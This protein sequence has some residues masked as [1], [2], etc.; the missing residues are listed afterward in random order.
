MVTFDRLKNKEEKVCVVGLGYV[1]LPLAVLFAKHFQVVGFDINKKRI[2]ELMSGTDHTKEV[3]D[4]DLQ[5]VEIDYTSD[6][7]RISEAKF[8]IVAVP[9]PIDEN[10]NP[11]LFLVEKATETV[12][13]HLTK[14]SVV[15]YESTVYPG[16]TEEICLPI[17]ERESGL[18][19]GDDFQIGY[20]P[21]RVN[22]G[23][24]QHTID[25]ITKVVAGYDALSTE[26][27]AQVYG[28]VTN[29]FK[30]SSIK[31]AEA[32]KAIENTQRDLNIAL[33]NELAI[34]FNKLG[35]STYDVLEAAGTKWNFLKFTPGLVG[36]HCI[37]VD[38]Y[39]LTYKAKA[40]GHHSEV[41]LAGRGINDSFHK[42]LAHQIIKQMVR[43][44]K[45]IRTSNIVILGLTFKE[46]I[47][48]IRNSKV[49]ELYLELKDFGV[50]PIVY[51]P[52]ANFEEVKKEYGIKLTKKEDL[53]KADTLV[54]AVA[55]DEFKSLSSDELHAMMNHKNLLFIDIKHLYNR[56][57]IEN[58]GIQYWT[59]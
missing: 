23:D 33:M 4:R 25:K 9:T 38:P 21:E 41:I 28:T 5:S 42:F 10:K 27:V 58:L 20:S 54:V 26:L 35:I 43:R 7:K 29:I 2:E 53:P 44:G 6:P 30:A 17:L 55:H 19:V 45:D 52:H 40:V 8:I 34:L 12:G 47:P 48:D 49:A 39:Y 56:R 32:A 57:E 14:D 16:V 37:G 3:S 18:K 31:V 11:D 50:E 51:D 13:K 46:N 59:L 15:V 1:G 24:K 36:G 22:P